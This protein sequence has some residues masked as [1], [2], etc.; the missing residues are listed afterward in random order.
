MISFL[1]YDASSFLTFLLELA[2]LYVCMRISGLPY[3]ASVAT[4]FILSTLVH[5]GLCHVWVFARSGRTMPFEYGYF[6]FILGSGLLWTLLLV[7]VLVQLVAVPVLLARIIIGL[8]TG[9]WNFYL[10]ARFNFHSP[11]SLRRQSR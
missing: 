5:Y 7:A 3:L 4:A 2:I 10:N 8:L 1:R 6:M 11:F 9:L